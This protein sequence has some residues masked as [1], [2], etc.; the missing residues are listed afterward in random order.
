MAQGKQY[1]HELE[2]SHTPSEIRRR[3]AEGPQHSYLRDFIYGAIDGAVTTFAVVS[4]VAGAGLN[5]KVVIILGVANLVGDGFSMAASNFLGVRAEKQ[6]RDLLRQME[7]Q[8]IAAYPEGER[9]EIREIF[10][11]KGFEDMDLERAVEIITADRDRWIQTML[12]EEHGVPLIGPSPV[13]AAVS[14]FAAFVL[15]GS[16][17]LLSFLLEWAGL[18]LG[19]PYVWSTALTLTA[20]FGIGALKSRFVTQT[21]LWAGLETLGLGGAAALLA[22]AVGV[23]LGDLAGA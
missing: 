21:W 6:Q 10:R 11:Q 2:S 3:L 16:V 20:F 22:Y 4:G 9:Q 14:T 13:R 18:K 7:S 5:S 17:P 19:D 15:V 23:A 8:H 1:S 12:T